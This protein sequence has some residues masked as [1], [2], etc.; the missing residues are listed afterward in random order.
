[1]QRVMEMVSLTEEASKDYGHTQRDESL[2]NPMKSTR[3]EPDHN[4]KAD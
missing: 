2:A 3:L 1:M 4:T